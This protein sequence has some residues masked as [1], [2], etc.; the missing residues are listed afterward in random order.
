MNGCDI[1]F[2][3][4]SGKMD[5][6][7]TFEEALAAREADSRGY[8]WLNYYSPTEENL[9]M[10]TN[11]FKIHFLT[12]EDCLDEEQIPK[13][14]EH[15]AYA[16]LLFNTFAYEDKILRLDEINLMVGR[17][18]LITVTR[19]D[20]ETEA[21]VRGYK[22]IIISEMRN[23]KTGP[24]FAMHIILD[25]IVDMKFSAIEAVGDDLIS[26][27]DI[28]TDNHSEFDHTSLQRIRQTLML[29]RKSLFHEREILVKICRN[30]IDVIPDKAIIHYNDIYDHITKFFELTEI[31]RE[32]VTNLIQTNLAIINND[33]SKAANNTNLSVKRLTVITTVFMPLT[34]LSGIFGMS[35]WTMM[36]GSDRWRIAYPAFF[37]ILIAVAAVNYLI[38]K[39]LDKR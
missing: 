25:Y 11:P 36:T 10:L 28:M 38:I 1:Y 8:L 9:D 5:T 4:D 12:I 17:D 24:S 16:Q 33:I 18:F 7:E 3:H 26:L 37:G 27:E 22:D 31:Y 20:A 19:C 23:A 6:L 39:L 21:T 35:E 2:I 15:G 29:L 30:D 34:L 13:I 32:M 14:F